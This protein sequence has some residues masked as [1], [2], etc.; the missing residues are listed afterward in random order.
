MQ[1]EMASSNPSENLSADMEI[2]AFRR[3]FP[4]QFYER[5]FVKSLRPDARSLSSARDTTVALGSFLSALNSINFFTLCSLNYR[6][7]SF[8]W[9]F[10]CFF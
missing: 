1:T 4:V 8:F 6:Q 7:L 5:H 2:D 9:K 3:L 10:N